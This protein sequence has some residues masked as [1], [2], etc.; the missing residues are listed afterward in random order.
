MSVSAPSGAGEPHGSA[1]QPMAPS[2]EMTQFGGNGCATQGSVC[3]STGVSGPPGAGGTPHGGGASGH[4]TEPSLEITQSGDSGGSMQRMAGSGGI[5]PGVAIGSGSQGSGGQ[6]SG[7]STCASAGAGIGWISHGAIGRQGGGGS[8]G[9]SPGAGI[10][11]AQHGAIGIVHGPSPRQGLTSSHGRGEP[12]GETQPGS[13]TAVDALA[14]AAA[15]SH[16]NSGSIVAVAASPGV[17][18]A[19]A[20]SCS[21][22][23]GAGG[24][25]DPRIA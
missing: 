14:Q 25:L 9:V 13:A 8:T 18:D 19:S 20:T 21:A 10:G 1:V 11:C 5:T 7:G 2:L 24:S 17:A 6:G 15:C 3:G 12:S 22:A 4:V 23:R 16:V